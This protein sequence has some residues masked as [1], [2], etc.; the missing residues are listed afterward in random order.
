MNDMRQHTTR[1]LSLFV[2][3]VS[4]ALAACG[5]I[6][7]DGFVTVGVRPTAGA[8]AVS[9]S[10]ARDAVGLPTPGSDVM[11]GILDG[12]S[13]T[14]RAGAAAAEA[15]ASAGA[16]ANAGSGTTAESS[17]GSTASAA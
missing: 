16:S 13:T 14:S 10:A 15:G 1:R 6:G 5:G 11:S 17:A 12:N 3:L 2:G 7:P 9:G 4:S 8:A